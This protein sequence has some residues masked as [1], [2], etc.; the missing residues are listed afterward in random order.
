[1]YIT[2][3]NDCRLDA[4]GQGYRP[5]IADAVTAYIAALDGSLASILLM[6]S[7]ARGEATPGLS[8]IFVALT[9]ARPTPTQLGKVNLE[10]TSLSTK[11][12]SVSRVDL[13]T[14]V[15]GEIDPAREFIFRTDSVCVWGR[16]FY[17]EKAVTISS[18]ILAQQNTADLA[19]L[20]S[21]YG[22]G[23]RE[24]RGRKDL[25]RWSRWTGK[26]MLK[27][28]RKHLIEQRGIYEKSTSRIYQKLVEYFP[29]ERKTFRTQLRLYAHPTASRRVILRAMELTRRANDR[30]QSLSSP[31]SWSQKE[32]V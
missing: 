15:V 1:M 11:Y 19:T 16:D 20:L 25:Q 23:V 10:Q 6:G 7:V 17:P 2:I 5:I 24:A 31:G 3:D 21:S 13:E 18:D 26:D 28:L 29:R 12:H 32:P 30:M 9:T 14:E 4:V 22:T 8:D 27:S